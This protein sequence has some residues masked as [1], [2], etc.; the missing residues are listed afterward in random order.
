MEFLIAFVTALN[1]IKEERKTFPTDEHWEFIS[2]MSSDPVDYM[3]RGCLVAKVCCK[4][5]LT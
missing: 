5:S 3:A 1:I 4:L 2:A